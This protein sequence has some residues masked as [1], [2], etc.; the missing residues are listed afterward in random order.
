MSWTYGANPGTTTDATR[1]DAVRYLTGDT[2]TSD[3]QLQDAEIA[4]CLSQASNDIYLASSI[5]ATSIAAKY[6]RLVDAAI[7][8]LSV[9]TAYSQRQKSYTELA[10]KLERQSTRFGKKALGIPYAGGI[11]VSEVSSVRSDSD[12]VDS[13]FS[14]N[15]L[16]ETN[17][18][19]NPQ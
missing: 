5:A 2:D 7:D 1:R 13:M 14:V 15:E 18:D 4:F 9:R 3:Q 19:V 11:S 12:R 17:S 6:G 8:D 16:S 10:R